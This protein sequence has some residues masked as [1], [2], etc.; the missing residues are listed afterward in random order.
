[1][2]HPL[3]SPMSLLSNT[4]Q[5][6]VSGVENMLFAGKVPPIDYTAL[7]LL[8]PI[9]YELCRTRTMS[10]L[11]AHVTLHKTAFIYEAIKK[12]RCT[13]QEKDMILK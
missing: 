6:K 4:R 1:M 11:W 9:D 13:I 8:K 3:Y 12:K 10:S 2:P 7:Y 5:K